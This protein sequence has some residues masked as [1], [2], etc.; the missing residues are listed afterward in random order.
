VETQLCPGSGFLEA[1]P[2]EELHLMRFIEGSG[3]RRN[4]NAGQGEA[5]EKGRSPGRVWLL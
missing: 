1:E 2:A 3:L 5:Q 4:P